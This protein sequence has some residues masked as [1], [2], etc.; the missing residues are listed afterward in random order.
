MFFPRVRAQ[1]VSYMAALLTSTLV[2]QDG[3]LRVEPD[4]GGESNLI[5]WQVPYFLNDNAG[6]LE[7]LSPDGAVLAREGEKIKLGGGDI[8][9]GVRLE[10]QLREKLPAACGGPY[11]L[12][13]SIER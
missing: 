7:I 9:S 8:D 2:V 11:F 6:S 12:M 10:C 5:I 4:Y 3:C 1:V 13:G